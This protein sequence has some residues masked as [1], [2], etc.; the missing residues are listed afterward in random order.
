MIVTPIGCE[1]KCNSKRGFW[2]IDLYLIQCLASNLDPSGSPL[3][4]WQTN[5]PER[6]PIVVLVISR[7]SW[8]SALLDG[9][10]Q[11]T[12]VA[13]LTLPWPRVPVCVEALDILARFIS[14]C[15][16]VDMHTRLWRASTLG[17]TRPQWQND[18]DDQKLLT[19]SPSTDALGRVGPESGR[20]EHLVAQ[21]TVLTRQSARKRCC[22]IRRSH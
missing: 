8:P 16:S 7:V 6:C 3:T 10:R 4:F 22:V 2:R 5:L 15:R 17:S 21:S 12:S 14:D 20:Y 13:A 1:Y 19:S 11:K 9:D 18:R